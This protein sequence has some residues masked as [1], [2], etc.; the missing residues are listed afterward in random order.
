MLIE[1]EPANEVS[2]ITL[3]RPAKLNAVTDEMVFELRAALERFDD[4]PDAKIAILRGSG[5]SFCSGADVIARQSRKPEEVA[6]LGGLHA[7]GASIHSV[8]SDFVRWK[9]VIAQVHGYAIG[10][11]LGLALQC[12]LIVAA[13][14]AKFQITEV[15]RGLDGVRL[16]RMVAARTCLGFADDVSI[17]GRYWSGEEAFTRGMVCRACPEDEL[18][19]TAAQLAAQIIANPGSS[20]RSLVRARRWLMEE[21]ALDARLR[22]R[23]GLELSDEFR[24]MRD[25]TVAKMQSRPYTADEEPEA[26]P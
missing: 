7:R 8:M 19:V 17:T 24:A 6:R 4:D 2:Y 25:Q 16:W 26:R 10:A 3:N 11:G 23:E 22:R 14:D 20:V 15:P 21:I 1:Y 13:S 5:R 12:D 9:P 18:S